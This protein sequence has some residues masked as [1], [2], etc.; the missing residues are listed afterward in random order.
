MENTTQ[1]HDVRNDGDVHSR[2]RVGNE[3]G[4]LEHPAERDDISGQR[5]NDGCIC[6][7]ARKR[8]TIIF[9]MFALTT[10]EQA[11]ENRRRA[12]CACNKRGT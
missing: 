8:E 9:D 3:S 1:I 2:D 4:R 10:A 5:S 11:A 7:M 6:G 12:N